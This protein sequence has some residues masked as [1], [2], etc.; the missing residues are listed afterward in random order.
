MAGWGSWLLEHRA[1]RV[2]LIAGLFP[3]G[4]LSL[5]SVALVV[6]DAENRGWQTTL[7]DCAVALAILTGVVL[8]AGGNPVPLALSAGGSWLIAGVVGLLTGMYGSL[9]LPIQALLLIALLSMTLFYLLVPDSAAYWAEFLRE[10]S[11]QMGELGFQVTDPELLQPLAS[12]MTGMV[13]GSA[14]LTS[15]AALCLG[16]W[17]GSRA[18]G[19]PFRRMFLQIR[20]GFVI[21]GVAVLAGLGA[22]LGAQPFSGNVLLVLAVGLAVQG[23]AVIHWHA[24]E[25]NWPRS[26]FLAVYLPLFLGPSVALITMFLLTALGFM[27][28]WYGLRRSGKSMV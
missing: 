11:R 26:V 15:V 21:G 18:G 25:R 10:F 13:A 14:T 2:A 8:L 27:D 3:L 9:T 23:L 6:F 22:M 1:T 19:P 17:W 24:V 5:L 28:N 16:T 4:L 7:A 12:V 20:M